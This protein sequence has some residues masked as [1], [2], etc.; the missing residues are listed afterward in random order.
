MSDE[1]FY[2]VLVTENGPY[3]LHEKF[4]LP[5]KYA[6]KYPFVSKE[7]AQKFVD[8]R[9]AAPR[10]AP[11][12]LGAKA[13]PQRDF[14]RKNKAAALPPDVRALKITEESRAFFVS[15][16]SDKA[17][18]GVHAMCMCDGAGT[19]LFTVMHQHTKNERAALVMLGQ[20]LSRLD[21]DSVTGNVVLFTDNPYAAASFHAVDFK[22][23]TTRT[24][25]HSANSNC[26]VLVSI[27]EYKK[28]MPGV[29]VYSCVSAA[30][31][32][33]PN[34]IRV[35]KNAAKQALEEHINNEKK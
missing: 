17:V 21:A 18:P 2:A 32:P 1:P 3:T 12:R 8:R 33:C 13:R 11:R 24:R 5:V 15:S 20:A 6:R 4:D 9:S 28:K 35:V 27:N 30:M 16:A 29:S 10:V 19:L 26:D 14:A 31:L 25:K 7:A 22:V 34:H 23:E